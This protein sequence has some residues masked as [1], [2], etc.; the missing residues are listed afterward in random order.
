MKRKKDKRNVGRPH[1]AE[2][3]IAKGIVQ[4]MDEA[5]DQYLGKEGIAYVNPDRISTIEAVKLIK[6]GR[7]VAVI[8]HPGLYQK[9]DVIPLLVQEGLDGIEVDHPDHTKE[10][11]ARYLKMAEE[12]DLIATAGSDFHGERNG[13]M[14]H[15]DLGTCTV[16]YQQVNKLKERSG[17]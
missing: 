5:F 4:S 11:R 17:W 10:D 9:D 1:I 13:S 7:G 8:A 3:L 16:P 2:V 6:S 12:Y 14:H 15:A